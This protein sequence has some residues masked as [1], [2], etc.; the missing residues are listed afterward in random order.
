MVAE[1]SSPATATPQ[2]RFS[3]DGFW[4]WDGAEWKPAV[5]ADRLWRWSGQAW[6]PARSA[7]PA[8]AGGVGKAIGMTGAIFAGVVLLVGVIVAVILLTVG[9]AVTNVLSNVTSALG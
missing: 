2:T 6:V 1:A 3:E 7:G 4:W 8:G 9:T 5:S